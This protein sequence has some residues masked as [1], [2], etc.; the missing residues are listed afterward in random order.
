MKQTLHLFHG[1]RGAPAHCTRDGEGG[2]GCTVPSAPSHHTWGSGESPPNARPAV[3]R[4][5]P[6]ARWNFPLSAA[7]R[8][9]AGPAPSARARAARPPEAPPP[10]PGVP[11]GSKMAAA[12]AAGLSRLGRGVRGLCGSLTGAEESGGERRGEP[13]GAVGMGSAAEPGGLSEGEGLAVS[14]GSGMGRACSPLLP[15]I[16]PFPSLFPWFPSRFPTFPPP[17]LSPSS[18]FLPSLLPL[19]LSPC[20][21]FPPFPFPPRSLGCGFSLPVQFCVR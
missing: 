5:L 21:S 1:A 4:S 19:S 7:T 3:G 18:P 12:M 2:E 9:P 15:P 8:V 14:E 16:F 6:R 11:C 13:R 17:F 10:F 20:S